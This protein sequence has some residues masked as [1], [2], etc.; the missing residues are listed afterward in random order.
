MYVYDTGFQFSFAVGRREVS[1]AE[2][3]K[4]CEKESKRLILLLLCWHPPVGALLPGGHWKQSLMTQ[5]PPSR[6]GLWNCHPAPLS[7]RN[8]Q[9]WNQLGL[10]QPCNECVYHLASWD[11]ALWQRSSTLR[12]VSTSPASPWCWVTHQLM[13]Y[14]DQLW[15]HQLQIYW[16]SQSRYQDLCFIIDDTLYKVNSFKKNSVKRPSPGG[17][18]WEPGALSAFSKAA[19]QLLKYHGRWDPF[20]PSNISIFKRGKAIFKLVW[21]GPTI[22][23]E[24]VWN[25]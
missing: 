18:C 7:P 24:E 10:F 19:H 22:P 20:C 2:G 3:R 16:F 1:A 13:F 8:G 15:A 12:P 14:L 6:E 25:R 11:V 4:S 21:R 23:P 5:P 17:K 9:L